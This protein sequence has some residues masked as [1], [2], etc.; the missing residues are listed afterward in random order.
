M[1]LF[2][3]NNMSYEDYFKTQP[4]TIHY[5]NNNEYRE[6]IRKV[7][8]FDLN[9]KYNYDGKMIPFEELDE[10]TKDEVMFDSKAMTENMD[11]LYR[12]TCDNDFFKKLYINAAGHMFSESPHIGQAV[13]CAYD[14]FALYYACVR[15]YY[16]GDFELMSRSPEYGQIK[17]YFKV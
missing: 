2:R 7:F 14:T 15:L 8:R 11:K 6:C 12:K 4:L 1:F 16:Q 10:I 5:T 13:L 17:Q 9:E 3:K